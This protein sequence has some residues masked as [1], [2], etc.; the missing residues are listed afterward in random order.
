MLFPRQFAC[1]STFALAASLGAPAWAEEAADAEAPIVVTGERPSVEISGTKTGTAAIDTPQSVVTLGRERLDDQGVESLGEALR[2][3]P[4]VTIGQGEG[5]RD[6]VILRGQASTADFYLDG[7]RDDAQYYRPLYNVQQIEVLKGANALLFG[8]GGGGGVINRT[9]KQ[10]QLGRTSL[11]ASGA[12]DSFGGWSLAGD[13]NLPVSENAALRINGTYENFDNDRDLFGGHFIGL[14]PTLTLAPADGTRVV[15]AYEYAAD[16]RVIDRGVPSLGGR[17]IGGYDQAFFGSAS[18]NTGSVD[19]HIA[20]IRIDQELGEGLTLDVTGQY[21]FYDKQYAN[22]LPGVATASTVSFSGY[23]DTN[24]RS[25]WIGQTNLVWKG[26]TGGIGHTLLVGGEIS[27]QSTG[28]T[29]RNV[30]FAASGGGTAASATLP[31]A[32]SFSFPAIS[33]TGLVTNGQTKV[34]S[35]SLYIQDQIELAPWLQ[36]IGGVRYDRFQISAVNLLTSVPSAR[37][38]NKWSPRLGLVLKPQENLSLYASYARSFLPQ[39]GDQFSSL[40]PTFQSLEPEAF[41]NLE[42]GAKWDVKPGLSLTLAAFQLDRSNTRVADPANPG[43]WL[44]TGSSRAHGI[45]AAVAGRITPQWQLSLGYTWQEGEIRTATTAAPAGRQLDKLPHHQASAWTRYDLT[46]RFGLG[47]GVLHQAGQY[48]TISNAVRLP[49]YTRI[50]AAAF[51]DVSDKFA[52][53]L[54]VEN[55]TDANYYASA[56]TDNNIQPGD[57][58]NVKLTARLKF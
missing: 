10:A 47:L 54:N 21:A 55:L 31:L 20:R 24:T 49:A 32:Q 40:N 28:A 48:A 25:N 9:S 36:V 56:H 38:D 1:L 30:L 15:L 52:L 19:A 34:K 57:P 27:D 43:F 4:G 29:R 42:A 18:V 37:T 11:G 5:H 12:I 39:S 45:E 2:F 51:F 44:L 33:W 50:D 14:A 53:Q 41:R 35:R 22:L 3:V 13:L 23:E 16:D 46:P 17:P 8:R 58:L 6:Q 7:L 26:Q